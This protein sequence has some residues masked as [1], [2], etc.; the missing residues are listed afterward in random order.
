MFEWLIVSSYHFVILIFDLTY[1]SGEYEACFVKIEARVLGLWLEEAFGPKL[2]KSSFQAPN[3]KCY[4]FGIKTFFHI[5]LH[6]IVHK[7]S[8][9]L[10]NLADFLQSHECLFIPRKLKNNSFLKE[11]LFWS[12]KIQNVWNCLTKQTKTQPTF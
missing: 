4:G 11:T 5:K 12:T 8:L 2:P 3:P 1:G 10:Q 6:K 9:Y 7:I